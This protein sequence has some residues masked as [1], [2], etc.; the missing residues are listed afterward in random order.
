MQEIKLPQQKTVVLYTGVIGLSLK[1]SSITFNS[2]LDRALTIA[3][4]EVPPAWSLNPWG[5]EE[6]H[7]IYG[8]H[9]LCIEE[10]K[11]FPRLC[12]CNP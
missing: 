4:L 8:L 6:D 11:G 10:A 1:S 12:C 2:R 5:I 9:E 3:A 7:K